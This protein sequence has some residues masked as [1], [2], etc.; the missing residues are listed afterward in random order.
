MALEAKLLNRTRL[1]KYQHC[2]RLIEANAGFA[3]LWERV[4][5]ALYIS[6][7][8][9]V[10][11][12]FGAD[13]AESWMRADQI[14]ADVLAVTGAPPEEIAHQLRQYVRLKREREAHLSFDE[15]RE[16][17]YDQS[18]YPVVTHFTY[19]LQPSA[20]ARLDFIKGVVESIPAERASAADLG[21]GSGVILSEILSMKPLWTGYGL[22]I[23]EAAIKYAR[24]VAE[25]K[26]VGERTVFRAIDIADLPFEDESL[27][28]VVA[29]EIIEHMPEPQRV[30]NEIARVLRP[31][32]KIA[33]TMPLESHTPAHFHA[34]SS[35]EDLRS[36]CE[37]AGLL[38]RRLE[39]RWH[40]GFGD[41]RRHIFTM[42]EASARHLHN[43]SNFV[44]PDIL[45][46]FSTAYPEPEA[47]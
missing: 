25:H 26:G 12:L 18:F 15:A 42:A 17:I 20:A 7:G 43:Q 13:T 39:P 5:L 47:I 45:Q 36:L 28:L 9:T 8:P 11:R 46:N 6:L 44:S 29:S 34:L 3:P 14:I 24:R 21:C 4:C 32:G 30:V 41:D 27:D 40:F 1:G 33:I 37:Q 38:V 35:G 10:A 31:H 19:A 22:D 23:S 2:L 16:E